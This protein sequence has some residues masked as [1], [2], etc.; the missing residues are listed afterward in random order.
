MGSLLVDAFLFRFL[1]DGQIRLIFYVF[2]TPGIPV[3]PIPWLSLPPLLFPP[4]SNW[5]P[6]SSALPVLP[7]SYLLVCNLFAGEVVIYWASSQ[8]NYNKW[9]ALL[10]D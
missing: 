3:G 10:H 4:F 1:P 5:L 6:L 9:I 8:Q 7:P 2:Q